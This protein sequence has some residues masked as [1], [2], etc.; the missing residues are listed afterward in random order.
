MKRA[1]DLRSVVAHGGEPKPKDVEAKDQQVSLA[2][3]VHRTEEIVRGALHKAVQQLSL[4]S[5]RL[6]IAWEDLVLPQESESVA[7]DRRGLGG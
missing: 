7:T 4:A 3:F 2:E 6:P 5:G 1:Y